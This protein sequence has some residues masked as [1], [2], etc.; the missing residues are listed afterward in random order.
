MEGALM[1]NDHFI[2]IGVAHQRQVLHSC[3]MPAVHSTLTKGSCNVALSRALD[4]SID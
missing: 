3:G 2:F 1:A 4:S